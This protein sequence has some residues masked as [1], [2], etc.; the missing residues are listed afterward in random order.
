M[1]IY[2][3][4]PPYFPHFIR[5]ARWQD[6]GRGG[7][8]YYPIWLSYATSLLEKH[9]YDVRL[10]DA[11]AFD[12]DTKK[13]IQDVEEFNPD[14]LVIE[15]S[16]TSLN[17]DMKVAQ[18]I[19]SIYH[20]LMVMVGPPCSLYSEDILQKSG[21]IDITCKYEYEYTLLEIAENISSG[22]S[23]SQIPGICH[24]LG[25]NMVCNQNRP[26]TT[27][28]QL[29]EI[30]FV[31][32]IYN[33]HLKIKDY[34]LGSSLYPEVQI[35]TGRGCPF[36]CTFCSWPETLMGRKYRVRS[37]ENV[38]AELKWIELNLPEVKEVFF[39]DDTFTINQ[40]RVSAFCEAY[41][42]AGL[43]I[44]WACNARATLD[45]ST[46][47]EMKGAGCR[48]VIVGYESGDQD[49][50][51][52]I[53]KDITVDDARKFARNAKMAGLLVHG[54]FVVGLP[55]ET[56]ET[57]RS[58]RD[59]IRELKP[60][61]LQVSVATPLPGT[62]FYRW[63]REKGYLLTTDPNEY[64][65]NAGHQRAIISYPWL[66]EQ[67]IVQSVDRMLR[68]Y[69]VTPSYI[70]TAIRQVFRKNGLAE[71]RR[72]VYSAKMFLAYSNTR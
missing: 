55:D 19:K 62:E 27:G 57:I 66:S 72:I 46:M 10:V 44:A 28:E 18:N 65:D 49:I 7:T 41:R 24:K 42:S 59:L 30:P 60:D 56:K 14:L 68:D 43:H 1:K 37:I 40:K 11:P 47:R 23:V 64:L 12:W 52:K 38:I 5:S 16:F 34:F 58:T 13:V 54:D 17:N 39:E 61:I 6:T 15:S 25:D 2:L 31:S 51:Q 69:Y 50:L 67:E 36:M 53:K 9:N 48:L 4:N 45:F 32:K 21:A 3:L 22:K 33:E 20:G 26:W 71:L 35:F 8:L 63:A 70:P 29:D